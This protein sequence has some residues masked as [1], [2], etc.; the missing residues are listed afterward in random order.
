MLPVIALGVAAPILARMFGLAD[1]LSILGLIAGYDLAAYIVGTG[2]EN[3]WEGPAAGIATVAAG[4]LAVAALAVPPF[5][6]ATAG[7]LAV[8]ICVA[9]P[10]G[11]VVARRIAPLV[12]E[13][14]EENEAGAPE[15]AP[16]VRRLSTL[17][18]A[19]PALLILLAIVRL[20]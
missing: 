3:R 19:G 7:L 12:Y 11:P 8:I 16:A 20:L 13:G 14:D 18:A 6:L 1:A 15:E 5:S 17:C 10:M 2:A 9:G 4:A